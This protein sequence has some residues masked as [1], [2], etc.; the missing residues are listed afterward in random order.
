MKLNTLINKI[1]QFDKNLKIYLK[2]LKKLD[3]I[4]GY[5]LWFNEWW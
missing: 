3:S 1:K 2:K 4:K 5:D